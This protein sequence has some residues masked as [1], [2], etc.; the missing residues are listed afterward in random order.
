M[1]LS[2]DFG[3]GSLKA[4]L[5]KGTEYWIDQVPLS[6][7]QEG[8]RAEQDPSLWLN[9]LCTAVTRLLKR[10]NIA[11]EK[12]EAIALSSHSPSL[13]PV[14]KEGEALLPCLTW[15]DRRALDQAERL[16]QELGE[17]FDPSF[18]SPKFS[19]SRKG[20]RDLCQDQGFLAA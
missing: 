13:V 1:Y 7:T 10:S 11:A 16:N 17:F 12:L 2:I 18:S 5:M 14:D 3:T 19:G 4:A 6:L 9:A 8:L 15:Q 20:N